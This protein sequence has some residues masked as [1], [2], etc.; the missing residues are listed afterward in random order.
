MLVSS[1]FSVVLVIRAGEIRS[2]PKSS[3]EPCA[4][5]SPHQDSLHL[6]PSPQ[7]FRLPSASAGDEGAGAGPR[8]PLHPKAGGVGVRGLFGW[9]RRAA[10][11]VGGD[12]AC[13]GVWAHPCLDGLLQASVG[14]GFAAQSL[15]RGCFKVP[16]TGAACPAMPSWLSTLLV[17]AVPRSQAA[18]PGHQWSLSFLGRCGHHPR[19][20]GAP[21]APALGGSA[22]LL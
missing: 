6:D 11:G 4:P 10:G 21:W 14:A 13:E 18:M 12:A 1:R 19:R 8:P 20:S 17:L 15:Q 22:I 5:C 16:Q 7:P 2:L 9:E 3:G